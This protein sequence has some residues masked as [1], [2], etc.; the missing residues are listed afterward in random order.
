L[1]EW[2]SAAQLYE[3]VLE[4]HPDF[5]LRTREPDSLEHEVL[6]NYQRAFNLSQSWLQRNP[7]DLSAAADLQ[8]GTSQPEALQKVNDAYRCCCPTPELVQVSKYF[9]GDRSRQL[10]R[11]EQI[12]RN[13][14]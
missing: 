4:V 1:K 6:F 12:N 3:N 2:T 10:D 11:I 7:N 14:G 13:H 9:A 5:G 8:R